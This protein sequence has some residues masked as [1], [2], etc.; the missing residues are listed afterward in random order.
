MKLGICIP[1]GPEHLT[2]SL[3]LM[4]L[5]N[6]FPLPHNLEF[7][8]RFPD[9]FQ[10]FNCR[11]LMKLG[12]CISYGPGVFIIT[13]KFEKYFPPLALQIFFWGFPDFFFKVSM[14][15]GWWNLIFVFLMALGLWRFGFYWKIR[16]KFSPTLPISRNR[17]QRTWQ[18]FRPKEFVYL[19]GLKYSSSKNIS[20]FTNNW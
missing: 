17:P 15:V 7:F 6:N 20:P 5:K 10:S 8:L 2:F 16:N 9:F 1:Y 19:V 13:D 3:L 12:I 4:N 14:A 18:I 11:R